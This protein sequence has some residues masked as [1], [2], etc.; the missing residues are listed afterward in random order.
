MSLPVV[1]VPVELLTLLRYSGSRPVEFVVQPD[2]GEEAGTRAPSVMAP[3]TF[4]V[5]A[6]GMLPYRR[7]L[8]G[9]RRRPWP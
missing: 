5:M 8:E 2:R 3:P 7:I 9:C 4:A 6:P 1:F